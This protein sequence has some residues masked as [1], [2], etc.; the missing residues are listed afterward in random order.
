MIYR[1][2]NSGIEKFVEDEECRVKV[3]TLKLAGSGMFSMLMEDRLVDC[4]VVRQPKGLGLTFVTPNYKLLASYTLLFI[5]DSSGYALNAV[6]SRLSANLH[7]VL[8]PIW[9]APMPPEEATWLIG[10]SY[11]EF[12]RESEPFA[13]A[14][15]QQFLDSKICTN[16]FSQ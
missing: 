8:N 7:K 15:C 2:V 9:R 3:P 14:L 4:L 1:H 11:S 13:L 16:S 5:P 6:M 10:I 12:N